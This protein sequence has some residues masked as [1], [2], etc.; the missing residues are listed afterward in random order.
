MT[1]TRP[2]PRFSTDEL[3]RLL[4]LLEGA[5]SVELKLTVPDGDQR[6]AARALH[7][8]PLDA[9]LSQVFFLDTRDLLLNERGLIVRA[10][11]TRAGD[12]SVVK[13]RPV[14]PQEL[15]AR[16]RASR[17]F[18]VE[19]DA[20]PGGFV[21]SGRL[22]SSLRR[23]KVQEAVDGDRAA[24]SLFNKQQ[25]AFFAEHAPEGTGI[26]DLADPRP[27]HGAQAEVQASGIRPPAGGRA[28]DLPGRVPDPGAVHQVCAVRGVPGG[29]SRRGSTS[30][31]GASTC[32]VSR[33]PRPRPRSSSSHTD[34]AA[35]RLGCRLWRRCR[36]RAVDSRQLISV[37]AVTAVALAAA[38][39]TRRVVSRRGLRAD[40]GGFLATIVA[41]VIIS[42][43]AAVLGFVGVRLFEGPSVQEA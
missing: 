36:R 29:G 10:R 6:S 4:G 14:V 18:G 3:A 35:A 41:A 11:R 27:D 40:V 42:V 9:E 24:R 22:K 23:G 34:A 28:V 25:R 37:R 2:T 8:D 38:P 21:C 31:S 12:D 19:V 1:D 20:M 33:R 43:I 32:R 16:L 7:M 39:S 13:L 30:R 17:G 26:D 15:P 5:D